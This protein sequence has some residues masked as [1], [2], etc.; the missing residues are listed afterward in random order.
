MHDT[1]E[2]SQAS[3]HPFNKYPQYNYI[4]SIFTRWVDSRQFA[5]WL[6]TPP[7]ELRE[8]LDFFKNSIIEKNKI[9]FEV[10]KRKNEHK[11]NKIALMILYNLYKD[12]LM[13]DDHQ[14]HTEQSCTQI[15]KAFA[16]HQG[17]VNQSFPQTEIISN[18]NQVISSTNNHRLDGVWSRNM[19]NT[20]KYLGIYQSDPL[21]ILLGHIRFLNNITSYGFYFIRGGL[22]G[23]KLLLHVF[24]NAKYYQINHIS[25]WN[26][27]IV[28]W[29]L[30][31]PTLVNDLILWAPVNL[32]CTHFLG[33][34]A[35]N[36]LTS[37]LLLADLLHGCI[38]T[39]L[40]Y[41]KHEYFA[42]LP[43]VVKQQLLQINQLELKKNLTQIVYQ[44]CLFVGFSLIPLSFYLAN[45]NVYLLRAAIACVSLQFI[46]NQR[47]FVVDL[48]NTNTSKDFFDVLNKMASRF[49]VQ[50]MIPLSF[51]FTAN[52]FMPAL[53][54]TTPAWFITCSLLSLSTML[55]NL[56][57][58]YVQ[59]FSNWNAP[60]QLNEQTK[61]D[62]K[63]IQK[64][65][66]VK[67]ELEQ[68]ENQNPALADLRRFELQNLQRIYLE[69]HY[70]S[71]RLQHRI[72]NHVLYPSG[73]LFALGLLTCPASPIFIISLTITSL[74]AIL[75]YMVPSNENS[76]QVFHI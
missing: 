5:E 25:K 18:I 54:A 2:D 28:Q 48:F 8:T 59:W 71:Q 33:D 50:A 17:P 63:I 23:L 67:K 72:I 30:R 70:A 62:N 24:D 16:I 1:H 52:L 3:E 27:F 41:A 42:S 73:A 45:P 13:N 12:H 46:N 37:A 57:N 39:Y 43:P 6:I 11:K 44:L 40:G 74:T 76:H 10:L 75:S 29:S 47:E 36:L 21:D 49:L 31:F 51:F 58:D 9:D 56:S 55:V 68:L 38:I 69:K 35:S 65:Q 34:Q 22:E 60:I 15:A 53:L 61:E 66:L 7:P 14:Q 4:L 20:L 32:L 26:K 64:A 19:V